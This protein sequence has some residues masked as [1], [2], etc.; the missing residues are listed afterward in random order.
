MTI[1][2]EI[3]VVSADSES[4]H[5]LTTILNREGVDPIC[6]STIS[7][8]REIMAKRNVGLVFCD[9]RLRDG[10]YRDLLFARRSLRS[11]AC[12]V[13]TSPDP[14][15]NEYLDAM[16]L[17]AFDVIAA[18]CRPTDVARMVIQA[19]RDERNRLG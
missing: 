11:K 4:R 12:V 5:A 16:R 6:T 18:P 15:W 7:D 10:N 19:R 14:D 3:L 17:G 13:V 9:G 2:W 8:C 1:P